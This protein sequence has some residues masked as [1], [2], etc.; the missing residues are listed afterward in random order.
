[1]S[2]SAGGGTGSFGASKAFSERR[3]PLFHS[4]RLRPARE[5]PYDGS[6]SLDAR[7]CY[8]KPDFL[9][10][11]RPYWRAREA[12]ELWMELTIADLK[13]FLPGFESALDDD[14]VSE[15]TN[16]R[17]GDRLRRATRPDGSSGGAGA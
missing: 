9:P 7:R 13:P 2:G 1:M 15:L 12:G 11:D 5:L 3:E 14:D 8:L 17:G 4:A 6:R 10:R 16:Q